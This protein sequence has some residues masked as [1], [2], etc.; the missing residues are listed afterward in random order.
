MEAYQSLGRKEDLTK[1][2]ETRYTTK[3]SE[4]EQERDKVTDEVRLLQRDLQ[5]KMEQCSWLEKTHSEIAGKNE[6]YLSEMYLK[7][8]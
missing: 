1:Q 6:Q 3:L 7:T 8:K 5:M 4:A 2:I